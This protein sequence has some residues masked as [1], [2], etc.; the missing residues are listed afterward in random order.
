MAQEIIIGL[1]SWQAARAVQLLKEAGIYY[2]A[3]TDRTS[4]TI[5]RTDKTA[6]QDAFDK[7]GIEYCIPSESGCP[8]KGTCKGRCP[9]MD[10]EPGPGTVAIGVEGYKLDRACQILSEKGIRFEKD[11]DNSFLEIDTDGIKQTI[12]TLE[13]G[14]VSTCLLLAESTESL[15]LDIRPNQLDKAMTALALNGI[16]CRPDFS[17]YRM[18]I[19]RQFLVP[20]GCILKEKQIDSCIRPERKKP[21]PAPDSDFTEE[22]KA[23]LACP[24][25]DD[26][27]QNC[28]HGLCTGCQDARIY[29]MKI[30]DYKAKN[31]YALALKLRRRDAMKET[32]GTLENELGKLEATLPEFLRKG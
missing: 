29:E 17:A 20:V 12:R 9:S 30:R 24:L 25:P 8:C 2:G 28:V 16:P 4:I 21:A 19:P 10:L 22:E 23:M 15:T 3:D 1:Y 26:P 14:G 5:L 18:E 7:G 32:I 27:C 31:L 13:A 6:V 11:E